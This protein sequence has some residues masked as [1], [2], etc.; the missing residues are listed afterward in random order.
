[1]YSWNFG[2]WNN[3]SFSNRLYFI[4]GVEAV[5][6]VEAIVLSILTSPQLHWMVRASN[7]HVGASEQDYYTVISKGFRQAIKVFL[8]II[9]AW[10]SSLSSPSAFLPPV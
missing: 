9:V 4:Q 7:L 8:C 2:T 10:I 3:L 1:M 6:E 5:G